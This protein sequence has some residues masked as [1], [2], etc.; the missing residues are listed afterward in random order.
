MVASDLIIAPH[1]LLPK[2]G[3]D[4]HKFAVIACDQFTSQPEYWK[5]L[6]RLVGEAPSTLRMVFPEAYLSRVNQDQYIRAINQ[7]IDKYLTESVLRDIGV[8]FILVERVTSSNKRRLGLMLAIDLEAYSYEPGTSAPIRASE[9]T[10]VERIPPRLKIREHAAIEIPHVLVLFDDE[11]KTIIE[12]IYR[13]RSRLPLLYDFDL[14]QN[15]G[16]LRGYFVKDTD[17]IM[18]AFTKLFTGRELLLIIGD[19]NHSLATAKAHWDKIKVALPD[20]ERTKHP[21]RY[22]LVEATNIYDEGIEFEPIHRLVVKAGSD[23]IPGLKQAVSGEQPNILY[24]K[25]LGRTSFNLPSNSPRAYEQVQA[26]IDH[27]LKLHRDAEVDYIHGL[28]DLLQ[29][30]DLR[31][32]AVAIAMPALTKSDVFAYLNAGTVL[33]RKA[34]SMGHANDKRYYLESKSIK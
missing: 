3:V 9:A 22:S 17:S 5:E 32:D 18:K 27:Y 24:T 13:N 14:N 7:S 12:P 2:A 19:G 33:P 16:H 4:L 15:G 23:F 29:L 34:F 20:Q 31:D 28:D 11:K 25:K 21:A 26:Y 10:I 1:I 8:G 30:A 6:D